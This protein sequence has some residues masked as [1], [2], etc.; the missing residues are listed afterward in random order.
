MLDPITKII[1]VLEFMTGFQ[2][3]AGDMYLV[4]TSFTQWVHITYIDFPEPLALPAPNAFPK[5]P[6]VIGRIVIKSIAQDSVKV[7]QSLFALDLD[8][9]PQF[10]PVPQG[11]LE[12]VY[13]LALGQGKGSFRQGLFPVEHALQRRAPIAVADGP[14]VV[15]HAFVATD[16]LSPVAAGIAVWVGQ[17]GIGCRYRFMGIDL[18]V[19]GRFQHAKEQVGQF[20]VLLPNLC[21]A[22]TARGFVFQAEAA[23][24][25]V[26]DSD[27]DIVVT[28]NTLSAEPVAQV[29]GG[30]LHRL[31][32]EGSVG[33]YLDSNQANSQWATIPIQQLNRLGV[34]FSP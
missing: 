12:T 25:P 16:D 9:A 27:Q 3:Q 23:G 10:R 32:P 30:V 14:A 26:F 24:D 31:F 19:A 4:A 1:D 34:E 33:L 20:P 17:A 2:P 6:H 8:P 5:A 21:S 18:F 7:C 11:C 22:A 15:P 29:E 28:P 13:L